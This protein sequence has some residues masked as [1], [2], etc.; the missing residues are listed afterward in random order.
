[1]QTTAALRKPGRA[2]D[3]RAMFLVR[4]RDGRSIYVRMRPEIGLARP[5]GA[6][7]REWQERGEIPPDEIVQVIRVR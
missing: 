1:M 2:R 5:L 3:G 4:Y 6:L 7:A